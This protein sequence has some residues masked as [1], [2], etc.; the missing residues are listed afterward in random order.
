MLKRLTLLGLGAVMASSTLSSCKYVDAAY[1]WITPGVQAVT[2]ARPMSE[3][4]LQE[5]YGPGP[6]M[7]ITWVDG[8]SGELTFTPDGQV[9]LS[10]NGQTHH[11]VW[12]IKGRQL[13]TQFGQNRE[14]RCFHQYTDGELYDVYTGSRHGVIT[15]I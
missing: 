11:G 2:F 9:S 10:A 1:E 13:C 5:V 3:E 15:K 7:A 12:A 14:V 6:R 4:A 8:S